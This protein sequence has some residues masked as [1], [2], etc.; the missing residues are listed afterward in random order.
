MALHQ[1][2]V[3]PWRNA[4]ELFNLR[5]DFYPSL[6]SG[7]PDRRSAAL[8]KVAAWQVRARIPHAIEAT[9]Q[10]TSA[11]LLDT[12]AATSLQTRLAYS[13]AICRFV[14]GLLDPAQQS[15][16]ALPMHLLAKNLNLPASFVELRHA[17]T[18]EALPSLT[19][20]RTVALRALDWLWGD[21][22]AAIGVESD[23]TR[24]G[25]EEGLLIERARAAVKTWRRE[26][27]E[28]PLRPIKEGDSSEEG[29]TVAMVIRECA[30]LCKND[31]G[32]ETLIEALLEEKALIPAGKKKGKMMK[33]AKLLW[34]PLLVQLEGKVPGFVGRLVEA[35]GEVLK[36]AE[37]LPAALL[38]GVKK[39]CEI[40]EDA[41]GDAE[42]LAAVF[43]W[44]GFLTQKKQ[45][46]T[47][48]VGAG[49]AL[50]E[51]VK[52]ILLQPNEWNMQLLNHI[53]T[54]H[55][56]LKPKYQT[57]ADLASTQAQPVDKR[58]SGEK[59]PLEAI[60]A[61]IAA[62]EERFNK[63]QQQR[64]KTR[65]VAAEHEERAI[66]SAGKWKRWE[67]AWIAKPLGVV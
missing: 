8:A 4:S 46:G 39:G 11:L 55:P 51:L 23:E 48:C 54:E 34:T 27:R 15:Q 40:A 38:R 9:A 6:E 65:P 44:L 60:E 16:F 57:L 5:N 31:E 2:R 50:E 12:P 3:V 61:E 62:F 30:E 26:R 67:G 24:A 21:Y 1:P 37:D 42:F 22:W 32:M 14:N 25:A 52:Q 56:Q 18:H 64:A 66:E 35:M 33:G 17:A 43:A 20:L 36:A 13:T 53:F 45:T 58:K 63:V 47:G 59:R 49:V 41:P 28:N 10:L 7:E 19:V 29:K